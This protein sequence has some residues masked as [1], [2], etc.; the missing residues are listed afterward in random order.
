MRMIFPTESSSL[1]EKCSN[2]CVFHSSE[3]LLFSPLLVFSLLIAESFN[4]VQV[5]QAD[6]QPSLVQ[7]VWLVILISSMLSAKTYFILF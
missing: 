5:L 4:Q 2:T 3:S 1:L 7:V 6:G